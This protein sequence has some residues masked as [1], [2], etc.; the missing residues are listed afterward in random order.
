VDGLLRLA[1]IAEEHPNL[2]EIDLNPVLAYSE[3]MLVVDS[4]IISA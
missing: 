3:G 4:R 2:V 1:V